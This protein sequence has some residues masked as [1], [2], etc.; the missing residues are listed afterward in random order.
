MQLTGVEEHFVTPEILDAWRRLD[1]GLQ[2]LSLTAS[3]HGESARRLTDLGRGRLL[4]MDATG[5]DVAVLSLT[6][7]GV[8]NL[9]P[10]DAVALAR[11]TNDLLGDAVRARPDRLQGWATVPTPSPHAAADEL[12][13]AVRHLGLAGGML[14]GR[15]GGRSLDH[16]D[17]VPIFE[18]AAALRVPLYLHP[19]SPPTSVRSTY[20]AGLG[21]PLD[22]AMSTFGLGWHYET[23]VQLLRLILTGVFERFPELQVVTGHWG[24][25]VLFFLE[26]IDKLSAVARLPRSITSYFQTNVLVTPSGILSQRYLDWAV[27]VVG[28]E[29]LLFGSDYPFEFA[30]EAGARRFVESATLSLTDKEALASGNWHRLTAAS[31]R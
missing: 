9:A 11:S 3:S 31:K 24:E 27:E 4:D 25:T 19:Q 8:H 26:R 17:F 21:A 22:A 29:R 6:T 2:D 15:T 16:P 14:F 28:V 23:G 7:P 12:E 30:P 20:Y 18:A 1:P 10:A 5:L 13:R